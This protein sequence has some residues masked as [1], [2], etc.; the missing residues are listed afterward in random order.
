MRGWSTPSIHH[1]HFLK[2]P[3]ERSEISPRSCAVPIGKVM[4]LTSIESAGKV[5]VR[6]NPV[7][8]GVEQVHPTGRVVLAR[9]R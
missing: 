7:A 3:Q 8:E 5:R 4:L 9:L 2:D 1:G 6:D